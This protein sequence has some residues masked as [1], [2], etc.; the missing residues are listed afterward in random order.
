MG[1]A[2]KSLYGT[3]D[4]FW[5]VGSAVANGYQKATNLQGEHLM[6]TYGAKEAEK[7][8][9]RNAVTVLSTPLSALGS[10]GGS[11]V[12]GTEALSSLRPTHYIAK[13]E[14]LMKDFVKTVKADG[15]INN[16]ILYV[17]HNGSKFIVDGNHRFFTAQKLGIRNVPTQR[18]QLPFRGYQTTSDLLLSGKQPGWWKYF[19]P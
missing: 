10:L 4:A 14:R 7:M 1:A 11:V 9:M 17:E 6:S 16:N 3:F 2:S 13:S 12:D 8:Q 15:S 19:N 18:V 5:T